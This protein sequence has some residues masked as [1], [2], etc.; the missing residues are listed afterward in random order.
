LEDDDLPEG[1]ITFDQIINRLKIMSGLDP[2]SYTEVKEGCHK[3]LIH[4]KSY[5]ANMIFDD[6]ADDPIC[7]IRMSADS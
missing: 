1:E 4:G 6:S 7:Q 3:L 2:I 5:T